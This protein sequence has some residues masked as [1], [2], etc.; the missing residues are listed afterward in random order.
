LVTCTADPG[1][2]LTGS[3]GSATFYAVEE[4][5][6]GDGQDWAGGI[7]LALRIEGSTG[8]SDKIEAERVQF[9]VCRVA[10]DG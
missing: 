4:V 5:N 7:L 1:N 3:D 2:S 6:T 8:W 9:R 10:G